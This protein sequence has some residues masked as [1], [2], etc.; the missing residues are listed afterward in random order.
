MFSGGN[1]KIYLAR[2]LQLMNVSKDFSQLPYGK[3]HR[4]SSVLLKAKVTNK[5]GGIDSLMLATS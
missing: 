5:N 4:P 2:F 3:F 1:I